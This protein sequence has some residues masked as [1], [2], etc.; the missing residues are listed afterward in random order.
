MELPS[1]SEARRRTKGQL[2]ESLIAEINAA[3][4][5]GKYEVNAGMLLSNTDIKTL[6]RKGYKVYNHINYYKISWE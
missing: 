2:P 4:D 6:E 1:A 5:S 3:I